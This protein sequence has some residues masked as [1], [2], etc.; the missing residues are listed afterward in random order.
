MHIFKMSDISHLYF[1]KMFVDIMLDIVIMLA[2][3]KKNQ[4]SRIQ[5]LVLIGD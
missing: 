4:N 2:K 1:G 5:E 3:C